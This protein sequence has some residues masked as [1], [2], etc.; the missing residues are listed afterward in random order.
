MNMSVYSIPFPS[1]KSS[2]GDVN[3][4]SSFIKSLSVIGEMVVTSRSKIR[5]GA[6]LSLPDGVPITYKPHMHT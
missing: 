3:F 1:S 2:P 4:T 6:M 5:A